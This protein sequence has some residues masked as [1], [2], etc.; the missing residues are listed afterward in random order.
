MM[1]VTFLALLSYISC[2]PQLVFVLSLMFEIYLLEHIK[3]AHGVSLKSLCGSESLYVISKQ[4]EKY[5]HLEM[6]CTFHFVF[7]FLCITKWKTLPMYSMLL[8]RWW[9]VGYRDIS[10]S[11]VKIW[12]CS[13]WKDSWSVN[14]MCRWPVCNRSL[15]EAQIYK[16]CASR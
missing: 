8:M 13:L 15:K 2:H 7:I 12:L 14:T 1:L 10:W 4:L 3:H 6:L 9:N 11:G 5:V 16:K